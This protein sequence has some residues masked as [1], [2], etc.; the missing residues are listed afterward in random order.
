MYRKVLDSAT[1]LLTTFLCP[2]NF[3]IYISQFCKCVYLPT[4]RNNGPYF[5]DSKIQI[6]YIYLVQLNVDGKRVRTLFLFLI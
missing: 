1:Y 4:V 5:I 6:L 2:T 3:Y